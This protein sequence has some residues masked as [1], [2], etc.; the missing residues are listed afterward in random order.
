[1]DAQHRQLDN[2]QL[3][4]AHVLSDELQKKPIAVGIYLRKSWYLMNLAWR[5]LFQP[6]TSTSCL[7]PSYLH[8]R[9]PEK[10]EA[11]PSCSLLFVCFCSPLYVQF[12]LP[13]YQ[14]ESGEITSALLPCLLPLL[15][16][17]P[18]E[19][20]AEPLAIGRR[21]ASLSASLINVKK[22]QAVRR[23]KTKKKKVL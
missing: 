3:Y 22:A 16:P 15:L 12:H 5:C 1:M 8:I 13:R 2:S 10:A 20:H 7:P 18:L 23:E 11:P 19:A 17:P 9:T 21:T 6:K 4:H 14:K